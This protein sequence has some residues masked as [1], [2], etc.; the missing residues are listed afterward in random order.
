VHALQREVED[1]PR[2]VFRHFPL[3]DIHPHARAA[4]VAAEAV[5]ARGG[6]D[7]GDARAPAESTTASGDRIRIRLQWRAATGQ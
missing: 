5:V 4:A 2:F 7:P 6:R 1:C 3:E